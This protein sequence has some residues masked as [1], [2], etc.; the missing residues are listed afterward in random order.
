MK[1]NHIMASIKRTQK[2]AV[3]S[4]SEREEPHT[5]TSPQTSQKSMP[6]ITS[7]SSRSVEI[8]RRI[9]PVASS[10]ITVGGGR[11]ISSEDVARVAF[12]L[13]SVVVDF[14]GYEDHTVS[15]AEEKN[16]PAVKSSSHD[17]GVYP[18][19]MCR[20]AI[21]A[22]IVSLVYGEKT[23]LVRQIVIQRLVDLLN[24]G[25]VPCFSPSSRN[26]DLVCFL[27]SIDGFN[28]Y[29]N[30]VKQPSSIVFS[31]HSIVPIEILKSEANV[32]SQGFFFETGVC[33]LV[34]VGANNLVQM[35]DGLSAISCE[36]YG[37]HIDPFDVVALETSPQHRGQ[38]TSSSNLKILLEGSRRVN[39]QPSSSSSI[40]NTLPQTTGSAADQIGAALKTIEIELNSTGAQSSSQVNLIL[41]AAQASIQVLLTASVDRATALSA[42]TSGGGE[43]EEYIV[44]CGDKFISVMNSLY[45]FKQAL[46]DE[47]IVAL[48]VVGV[49]SIDFEVGEKKD[50]DRDAKQLK[51]EVDDSKYTPEQRAKA[52]AKRKQKAEK[53]AQKLAAKEAKRGGGL[54]A[55]SGLGVGT[56]QIRS[57]ILS[58][59][60]GSDGAPAR[61]V[62]ALS[63]V[64]DEFDS[65]EQSFGSFCK[66]IIAQ[67]S[68]QGRR[69]AR[70]PNGTRDFP[71][72]QMRIREQVFSAIRRVFKRHGGVEIDTPVFELKEV[73]TGK[74][75]ED[76]KLI[77]DL[78]DQGGE[79][80]A[81]RYDLTVPFA[82][83]LA[84]NTVGNIKRYHIAKVYRRDQPQ[85]T[86]GRYREFYQCDFDIA[87][88]Y[89]PMVADAEVVS[90][91][92]E[93]LSELPVGPFLIKLNHRK[94][95]DAIFEISG[96]P[97]EKFRPICSAVDKLDK[98]T[99]ADVREEMVSEKGLLPSVADKIGEFVQFRGKP[100]ELLEELIAKNVFVGHTG[101]IVVLDEMR[102]LFTYLESMGSLGNVSFDLSLARGLDYYTGVIYEAVL[103]DGTSQLGSISGG[104][105]Y[106]HLAGMFST[107]GLQTPCVGVSI[108]VE[109][110]FNIMERKAREL[111]VLQSSNIQVYVASIGSNLVAERMKVAKLLWAANI[112][113]E[114]SHHPKPTF[115]KQLDE[116]LERAIPF[117]VVFGDEELGKGTIKIKN[118]SEKEELEVPVVE[119]VARLL[120]RGC[121]VV[122]AGTDLGYLEEMKRSP[123]LVEGV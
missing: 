10:S 58:R 73:L 67:L 36:S 22:R 90:V 65:S 7:N 72:E 15:G 92:S 51:P 5:V 18:V 118:M 64:F 12:N 75:G 1:T 27:S 98:E 97:A 110:V 76:S 44:D 59:C 112:S 34:A 53:D 23:G 87:G 50:K 70:I 62:V 60:E 3:W 117:M 26:S 16:A 68:V 28:V 54:L 88:T 38:L 29:T 37:A 108:G 8:G 111:N 120:Q 115:K 95:L 94:L 81:L 24:L 61:R 47:A 83:F 21:F 66:K 19:E 79:L 89:S 6:K 2:F 11:R 77:Y 84:M 99:W 93:I 46:I 85:V 102:L 80:L 45:R 14:S 48:D 69:K 49:D 103:T 119:M 20:A 63:H 31:K 109:R 74:Y 30:E 123:G 43:G 86:R 121:G 114:Y 96:V 106:D 104:G 101:A 41:A 100:F 42:I 52:E 13:S 35:V 55:S 9:S 57:E 32:F 105:R 25:V 113:A 122:A 4:V 39:K 82:R 91:A 40:F 56:K 107:A 116:A 33:C 17:E 78:A 71:P